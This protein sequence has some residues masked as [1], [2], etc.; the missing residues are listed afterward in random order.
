MGRAI[1]GE[2]IH[3]GRDVVADNRAKFDHLFDIPYVVNPDRI[4]FS[5]AVGLAEDC[6]AVRR[7]WIV[8]K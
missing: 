1:D 6:V 2:G 5:I 7:G 4:A 3:L 8:C